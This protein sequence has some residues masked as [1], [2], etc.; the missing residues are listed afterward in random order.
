MR[1]ATKVAACALALIGVAGV[2]WGFWPLPKR[3]WH[4]TFAA[5]DVTLRVPQ[6]MRLGDVATATVQFAPH[7]GTPLVR[8][9]AQLVA[10]GLV[11][12]PEGAVSVTLA[13]D[14]PAT[15]TWRLK[16]D[17]TGVFVGAL[18]VYEILPDGSRIALGSYPLHFR[19]QSVLGVSG[20]VA[21]WLGV[22]ALTLLGF[23]LLSVYSSR[24]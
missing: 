6:T 9:E 3:T 23:W 2:L 24:F 13:S 15:L 22:F 5:A 14:Q 17:A 21:R 12:D 4:S 19:V 7:E 16:G 20:R 10:N 11:V 18:W 8:F 1:N